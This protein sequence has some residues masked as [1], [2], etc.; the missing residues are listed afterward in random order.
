MVE[1]RKTQMKKFRP[2]VLSI[3]GHDPSAGAGVLAD[4]KTLEANKAYGLG[5]VS[6][7]TFQNES[8]FD[9]VSWIS[10]RDIKK[11]AEVLYRK[12]RF[13][14]VKIGLIENSE[15]LDK[16]VSFLL[17][18][19]AKMRIIWDPILKASA[20]PDIHK[21]MEKEKL[22][23]VY[24]NIF[25]LTPNTSEARA[26]TGNPDE[27][28]AANE[29]SAYCNVYL[30]GGHSVKNTNKDILFTREGKRSTFNPKQT[31]FE[32]HGSGCVLSAA[33]AANL[34]KGY[35]LNAACLRG[36]RYVEKF[37]SS[38]KALSGYHKI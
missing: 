20:G 35:K 21:K 27:T 5:V 17:S 31:G 29:L 7:I 22:E 12:H 2:Y 6:A 14:V 23:P 34:A 30:K 25:L 16:L 37:L 9:E 18:L 26:L 15:V 10:E 24:K 28:A 1:G 3:G 19:D 38:N 32:K 11:Q 13:E 4:I 36:K 33:I 8:E